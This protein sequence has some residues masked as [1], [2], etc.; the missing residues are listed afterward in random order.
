M[1][2]FLAN[3]WT[4]LT[5]AG[6]KLIYALVVLIVGLKLVGWLCKWF[7]RSPR[8]EK[9][10]P[11]LKTFLGSALSIALRI[12]VIVSA[13]LVMGIPSAS[14]V[15]ILTSAGVAIGLAL[16]G[17]LSNLA[18][19]LMILFFKPFKV[20]DFVETSGGTGVVREIGVFYTML[21][22]PDGRHITIPNGALTNN[23]ITNFTEEP[24]RGMDCKFTVAYTS[25]SEQ[26]KAVLLAAAEANPVVVADPAP[27]VWMSAHGNSAL[28]YTLRVNC[29]TE[30]YLTLLTTINDQVKSALDQAGIEIPYQQVDVHMK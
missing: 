17:S 23:T 20:G 1:E 28:E 11:S 9:L 26:V 5:G 21:A 18:G 7:R 4:Q 27:V 16:Q 30:D 15:A 8:F 12:I 24:L 19:G 6:L 22:A 29:R 14:F 13:A 3:L 2:A 10:D 25:D